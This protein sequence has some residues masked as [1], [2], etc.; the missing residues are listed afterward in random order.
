MG[1]SLLSNLPQPYVLE[2]HRDQANPTTW[3]LR[4][5][6]Q[7]WMTIMLP[8]LQQHPEKA[9]AAFV[10]VGLVGVS[11]IEQDGKPVEFKP[12]PR[13]QVYGEWV[14]GGAPGE[15]VDALPFDV[16]LELGNEI[17]LRNKLDKASAGN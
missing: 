16:M 4:T 10:E 11:G 15:L 7:R 5:L 9:L 12:A 14:D 17:I 6:P 1:F 2:R 13:R 8:Q 3:F